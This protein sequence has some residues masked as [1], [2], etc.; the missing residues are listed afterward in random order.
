M[1]NDADFF[2]PPSVSDLYALRQRSFPELAKRIQQRLCEHET[3]DADVAAVSTQLALDEVGI[4]LNFNAECCWVVAPLFGS[5]IDA[6]LADCVARELS[7]VLAD[8]DS[9]FDAD[10]DDDDDRIRPRDVQIIDGIAHRLDR[11]RYL[12]TLTLRITTTS[13]WKRRDIL[14][15]DRT[16][17]VLTEMLGFG[18]LRIAPRWLVG[19]QFHVF[20]ESR[21]SVQ[22]CPYPELFTVQMFQ[23]RENADRVR[24]I[25][26][27]LAQRETR[28]CSTPVTAPEPSSI[29]VFGGE[30][31]SMP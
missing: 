19:L 25:I 4:P 23:R 22:W 3:M 20:F 18:R 10:S 2:V 12:N 16:F 8:D 29:Y 11:N 7:M 1:T 6:A 15:P 9:A 5:Q 21:K 13:G 27:A 30:T 28:Y 14:I 26:D 17:L 24:E 31:I